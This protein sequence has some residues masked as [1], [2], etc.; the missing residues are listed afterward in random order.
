MKGNLSEN[1]RR[2]REPYKLTEDQSRVVE[3]FKEE[4]AHRLDGAP[5][6]IEIFKENLLAYPSLHADSIQF[7]IRIGNWR[8]S[9][10]ISEMELENTVSGSFYYFCRRLVDATMAELLKIGAARA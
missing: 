9:Q 2:L 8:R 4:L 3:R 10:I 6:S 5:V 7:E 1:L